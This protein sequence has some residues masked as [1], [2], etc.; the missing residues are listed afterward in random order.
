MVLGLCPVVGKLSGQLL[1]YI[2]RRDDSGFQVLSCIFAKVRVLESTGRP[3]TL[4][5]PALQQGLHVVAVVRQRVRVLFRWV[6][7]W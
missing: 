3:A 4:V 2:P 1:A 5:E 6:V 7:L